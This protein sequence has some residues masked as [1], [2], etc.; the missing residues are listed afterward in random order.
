VVGP[1]PHTTSSDPRPTA[2][3]TSI[4]TTPGQLS[5]FVQ[6]LQIEGIVSPLLILTVS[7]TLGIARINGR[8]IQTT[9]V[10]RPRHLLFVQARQLSH[11]MPQ[12]RLPHCNS[13]SP[14]LQVRPTH[15]ILPRIPSRNRYRCPPH[16]QDGSR[17]VNPHH[18]ALVQ[19]WIN[20]N[21]AVLEY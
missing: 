19:K 6:R 21:L 11:I 20:E 2:S 15:P 3:S 5:H 14:P 10:P 4:H 1:V 8:P 9:T 18:L 7:E 12:Y 17:Q 13:N 16:T